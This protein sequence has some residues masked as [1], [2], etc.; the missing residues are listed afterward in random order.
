VKDGGDR[1]TS[2][3]HLVVCVVVAL[4][5]RFAVVVWG[6]GRFPPVADGTYYD[7]LA[8][9][10]A[11]GEGYTWAWPDG[12][13]S[14]AAHYPVGYPALLSVGY[15]AFGHK[16]WAAMAV[17]AVVGAAGV[18]GAHVLLREAATARGALVGA[19]VLA[20]H[21]VLVPYTAA[22]MTE[23]VTASLLLVAS[24]C[25]V[26]AKRSHKRPR[27]AWLVAAGLVM[28]LCTLV[29]P[30]SL[31]LA[32]ALGLLSI[33]A[34]RADGAFRKRV[35]AA[36]AVVAVAMCVI[37]PWTVRN[38][39]RMGR[40]APVSVNGG[41][42]LLIGA[43]STNGSWAPVR[44]PDACKDVWDEAQKDLCFQ[45]AARQEIAADPVGWLRRIP[46]KVSVTLDY[47]GGAPWY[48]H[49]SSPAA[50]G[51]KAK[52]ALGVV[53]TVVTRA[54]LVLALY[55]VGARGGPRPKLVRVLRA[56][57]IVAAFTVHG[58]IAYVALVLLV[59]ANGV[60]AAGRDPLLVPFTAT[61]VAATALTHSLFFGGGRYGIVVVPFV[62]ALAFTT[63]RA[64]SS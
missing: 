37:A 13:V 21:P 63:R 55:R 38:C 18:A 1:R 48:L 27:A 5:A 30:Q 33:R 59:A 31:A 45:V 34:S 15:V 54:L 8:A 26:V 43:Q 47:F 6:G 62:A 17:N 10:L 24:A 23:G 20:L 12:V 57:G 52:L 51:D 58:S 50:F 9:R 64:P 60:R 36:V 4:I 22:L 16:L 35:T 32:P 46:R 29:R 42:N 39:K 14:Y 19:L 41:W 7:A 25:V 28:G 11:A 53:E 2:R 44:V 56:I 40:C 49:A 3:L 61:L